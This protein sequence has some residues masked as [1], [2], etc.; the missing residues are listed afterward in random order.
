M[1]EK[2]KVLDLFSGISR[3]LF[4]GPGAHGRVRDGGV[5]R[6]RSVLP[7]SA[8]EALARRVDI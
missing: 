2:L 8:G 4:I 6:D 5:L 7:P 1:P 3:R